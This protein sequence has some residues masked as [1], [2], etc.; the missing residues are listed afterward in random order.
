MALDFNTKKNKQKAVERKPI[1]ID[2]Y[3]KTKYSELVTE[4]KKNG[5]VYQEKSNFLRFRMKESEAV[6]VHLYNDKL[7]V[8]LFLDVP[9]WRAKTVS[10]NSLD[11]DKYKDNLF[12]E[13]LK[14]T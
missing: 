4:L 12:V 13:L 2:V 14:N 8:Y 3:N 7:I 1:D 11:I 6:W 5:F 9:T 10:M